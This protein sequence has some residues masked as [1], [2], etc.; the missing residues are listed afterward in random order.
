MTQC[1]KDR[2][3]LAEAM[4]WHKAGP[5]VRAHHVCGWSPKGNDSYGYPLPDPFNDANDDFAVLEW[6]RNKFAD[7]PSKY[8]LTTH[9]LWHY[10][11]GDYARA[12]LKVL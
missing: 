11:I 8:G 2:T 10:R 9:M 1:D 6:L 3:R 5:T 12:A 4:G 7:L